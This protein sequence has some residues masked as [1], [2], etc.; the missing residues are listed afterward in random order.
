VLCAGAGYSM[1]RWVWWKTRWGPL[2]DGAEFDEDVRPHA[3]EA[4]VATEEAEL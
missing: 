2:D 3:K 1:D 4:L